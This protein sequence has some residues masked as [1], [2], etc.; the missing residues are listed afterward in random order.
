MA[1]PLIGTGTV[2]SGNA[3]AWTG[4][5]LTR[6]NCYV[7][8]PVVINKQATFV[9]TRVDTT[10]FTVAP[11]VDN[12]TGLAV[13]ISPLNADNVQV[14]ELNV[15]AAEL[16]ENLSV[17]D[18]NG[19]GLFYNVLS[20][21][22]ANDP[23]PGYLARNN[24]NW[25]DAT[26]LYV[27]A[28]DANNQTA[29]ERLL[30]WDLGTVL[31]IRS[32]EPDYAFASYTILAEPTPLNTNGW[33]SI[34]VTYLEG[35]GLLTDSEPVAVE[36]N[37]TAPG[38]NVVPS[39]EWDDA[40]TYPQLAMV[41]WGGAVFISSVEANLNHEPDIDP[42]P[43]S[44][45]YW[46][47][48]PLPSTGDFFDIALYAAGVYGNSE[49]L[50]RF[51]FASTVV[52]PAA[53]VGSVAN[54]LVDPAGTIT[55]SIRKNGSEFGT[56]NFAAGAVNATFTSA[57]GATFNVGDVLTVLAPASADADLSGVAI[58]IRGSRDADI[59]IGQSGLAEIDFGAFPGATYT[60]LAITGQGRM[61][62]TSRVFAQM[63]CDDGSTDHTVD[64]HIVTPIHLTISA[65]VD[66]TGFTIN[67]YAPPD[68]GKEA[69]RLYGKW[70]VAWFWV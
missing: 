50:F 20:Y 17:I 6:A 36:W 59:P 22:A 13:A 44:S 69:P 28:V 33:V 54:A 49:L 19:R 46:T 31:T 23:G 66:G 42:E 63:N 64:E 2:T 11:S 32:L 38:L 1:S 27:D 41:E 67:A 65:I 55:L 26:Q 43:T 3:V 14:A 57:S 9:A 4:A 58:T 5:V 52:F 68:G 25:P 60:S 21:T 10:H 62:A 24:N 8:M 12:G 29:I 16:M 39:G 61:V 40:V 51:E 53:L 35:D 7:G 37:R 30:L 18:A 48:F 34:N 70:N 56:V 45:A 15:R 47:L